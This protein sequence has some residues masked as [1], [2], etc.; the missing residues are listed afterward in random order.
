MI[1]RYS[2][3]N[4]KKI[5][6]NIKFVF[7]FFLGSIV[8]SATTAV[9]V[10]QILASNVDFT[11]R[12][13]SWNVDNAQAAINDLYYKV[14]GV[15]TGTIL[16]FMG[17]TAPTGYLICDGSTYNISS[18]S[19]LAN[20]IKDQFGSYNYFGGDGSTTFKVPDL[21]GEFLR[22]TGTNGHT[23][24]GSG[25]NVGVHQNGTESANLLFNQ[26][27]YFGLTVPYNDSSYR[28]LATNYD[29]ATRT[30]SASASVPYV[31]LSSGTDNESL[32]ISYT[33]R[34][35][36]TSVLYIIKY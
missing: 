28:A 31:T 8:T 23:N 20:F 29:S 25:S 13:S 14:P 32:P 3:E 7:A 36:N 33:S 15:P 22:G 35:T 4:M 24:Q 26:G 1:F 34:P 11:P 30:K 12:D 19:N 10:T 2:G 16:P 17:T 5:R 18:H 27:K 6:K 21:R 9:A